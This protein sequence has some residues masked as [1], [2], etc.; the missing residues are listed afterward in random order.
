MLT[1]QPRLLTVSA[2]VPSISII[3]LL[4]SIASGKF[5]IVAGAAG[6]EPATF[7]VTT[8]R[9]TIELRA[10]VYFLLLPNFIASRLRLAAPRPRAVVPATLSTL[11]NT[12]GA[13]HGRNA[14]QIA[15]RFHVGLETTKKSVRRI[16]KCTTS[17]PAVS[18]IQLLSRCLSE[19]MHT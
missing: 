13:V 17:V 19:R 4:S 8:E 10:C 1:L 9:S 6:L 14:K 16:A 7:R 2:Y 11:R 18:A 12:F 15:I 5:N 3:V